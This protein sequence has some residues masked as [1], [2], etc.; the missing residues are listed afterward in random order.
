M[1]PGNIT[2]IT[3]ENRTSVMDCVP[4]LAKLCLLIVRLN[5]FM[6]LLVLL[7]FSHLTR[8]VW[9]LE[10]ITFSVSFAKFGKGKGK[11]ILFV[12]TCVVLHITTKNVLTWHMLWVVPIFA[13]TILGFYQKKTRFLWWAKKIEI[14]HNATSY[15]RPFWMNA[16]FIRAISWNQLLCPLL[17]WWGWLSFWWDIRLGSF[18]MRQRVSFQN[19]RWEWYE[20]IRDVQA[21]RIH[22]E[23]LHSLFQSHWWC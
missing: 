13:K 20:S 15:I 18:R 8:I 1:Q 5:W 6:F 16:H 21:V 23:F 2:Y 12:M 9:W 14:L 3:Y 19:N 11:E 4:N 17:I 10:L 7:F 22:R